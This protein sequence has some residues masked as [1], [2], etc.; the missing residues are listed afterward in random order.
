M[1]LGCDSP[2]CLKDVLEEFAESD[3]YEFRLLVLGNPACPASLLE[4]VAV[5]SMSKC[6]TFEDQ[7]LI[8]AVLPSARKLGRLNRR[9][10]KK[11]RVGEF[12][13]LVFEV[14]LRFAAPIDGTPYDDFLDRVFAFVESRELLIGGLGGQ[15]PLLETT[16]VVSARRFDPLAVADRDALLNWLNEQSEIA[17]AECNGAPEALQSNDVEGDARRD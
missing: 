4:M 16:A 11:L 15:L 17:K 14:R 7:S 10:R 9:Q 1:T 8:E 3:Y 6:M 5:G 2:E 12:R 13:E